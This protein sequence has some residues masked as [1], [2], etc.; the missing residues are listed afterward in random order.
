MNDYLDLFFTFAKVGVMTFGGGY[1]MLPILQREVCETKK[2]ADNNEIMD[3]YAIGQCTPGIIA[4][5]VST[6]IGKKRKGYLGGI[7]ATLGMAFPSLLIIT[8]IA[9][10]IQN[11]SDILWVQNAFAGVRVCVSIFILSAV[12][13]LLKNAVID[14]V[15]GV[16]F[17]AVLSASLLL[18]ISPI[19][20]VVLSALCGIL[21]THWGVRRS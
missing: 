13:K 2:W 19:L 5:N 1:A 15:T 21:F 10:V 4:I 12:L 18:N 20:F 11:F 16:I 3:Y 7:I 17:V 9:A 14:Y 8:F 6:F